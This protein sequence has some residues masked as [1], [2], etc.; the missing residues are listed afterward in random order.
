MILANV[1]T[2]S[3]LLEILLIKDQEIRQFGTIIANR[4][5][6]N[7]ENDDDIKKCWMRIRY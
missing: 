3:R 7:I 5:A 6:A 1:I 2:D 4:T